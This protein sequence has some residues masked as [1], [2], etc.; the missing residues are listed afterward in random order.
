MFNEDGDPVVSPYLRFF[1]LYLACCPILACTIFFLFAPG[2]LFRL[3]AKLQL[4]WPYL[5]DQSNLAYL[6]TTSIIVLA[7]ALVG[8]AMGTLITRLVVAAE[9]RN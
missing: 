5:P 2:I 8:F 4:P 3:T 7:M 9:L 6:L 1:P